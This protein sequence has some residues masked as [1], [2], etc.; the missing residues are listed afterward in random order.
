M[1][2]RI[3]A[4][5]LTAFSLL[6]GGCACLTAPSAARTLNTD[7]WSGQVGPYEEDS[8]VIESPLLKPGGQR[9]LLDMRNGSFVIPV[10]FT[11]NDDVSGELNVTVNDGDWFTVLPMQTELSFTEGETRAVDLTVTMITPASEPEA[12]TRETDTSQAQTTVP[13]DGPAGTTSAPGPGE[14]TAA[15]E[16]EPSRSETTSAEPADPETS[17]PE[18]TA[19]DAGEPEPE[20]PGGAGPETT[21]EPEDTGEPEEPLTEPIPSRLSFDVSFTNETVSMTATF[22]MIDEETRRSEF[23]ESM[24]LNGGFSDPLGWYTS[25]YPMLMT[26][27]GAAR[28]KISSAEEDEPQKFPAGT[29]YEFDGHRIY[30]YDPGFIDVG[31]AGNLIIYLSDTDLSGTLKLYTDSSNCEIREIGRK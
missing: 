31:G 26:L 19:P 11:A 10:T 14:T 27:S 22:E 29:A 13:E 7:S 9:V 18:T 6:I 20:D 2:K 16:T 3:A 30:L 15:P 8:A 12:R 28:L 24:I 17:A 23:P 25:E 4:A 1:N 5:W 21:E